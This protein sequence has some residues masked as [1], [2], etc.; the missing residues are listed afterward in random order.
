MNSVTEN[1][2]PLIGPDDPAPVNLINENGSAR[3]LLVGDHA[4]RSIPKHMGLLGLEPSALDQ[5]IAYD[6]GTRSLIERLSAIFDAPAV[7]S[8]YSRLLVDC[9]RHLHDPSAFPE[10]SDDTPVPANKDLSEDD[11]MLRAQSFYQPYRAAI[12]AALAKFEKRQQ[13]PAFISIHSFTSSMNGFQRPWHVG[14]LWGDDPRMPLPVLEN[15]RAHPDQ[16]CVGDNEPYSGR[17]PTNFTINRHAESA[18]LP[19]VSF[20][21]RQNLIDSEQGVNYWADVLASTLAPILADNSLY[22]RFEATVV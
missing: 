10:V 22:Q 18:G 4:G 2:Y 3:L 16:L 14:V 5:H 20:E 17:H 6:I 19:H 9:N 7:M 12:D 8:E 11:K 15:L 13:I 1:H 21:I